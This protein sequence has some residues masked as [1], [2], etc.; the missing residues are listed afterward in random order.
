VSPTESWPHFF[1]CI[2]ICICR[3]LIG[4]M[5][6]LLFVPVMCRGELDSRLISDWIRIAICRF[7]FMPAVGVAIEFPGEAASA[8]S[9]GK[10]QSR[11]SHSEVVQCTPPPRFE[12]EV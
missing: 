11:L 7:C 4:L 10:S 9:Q 5:R 2:A 8:K 1:T 3:F 12:L 6:T